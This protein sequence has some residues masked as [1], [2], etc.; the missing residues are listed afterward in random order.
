MAII[1][2]TRR[3]SVQAKTMT[4]NE[5]C[6]F[7]LAC[8][9][10]WSASGVERGEEGGGPHTLLCETVASHDPIHVSFLNCV[11]IICDCVAL[12]GRL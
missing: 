6:T 12:L 10:E 2:H 4:K 8:E 7:L 5:Q 1:L 3:T 11:S 9:V